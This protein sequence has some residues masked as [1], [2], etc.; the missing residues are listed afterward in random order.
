M[1]DTEQHAG[2]RPTKFTP[3]TQAT[4]VEAIRRGNSYDNAAQL[5]GVTYRTFRNWMERGEL[6][7]EEED[8]TDPFFQFFQEATRANAE[9]LDTA[10][11]GFN[12]RFGDD[13]RAPLEALA[14]RDRKNWGKQETHVL[15]DERSPQHQALPTVQIVITPAYLRQVADMLERP[16]LPEVEPEYIEV[17]ARPAYA[18]AENG[19]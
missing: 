6:A 18:A 12:A 10:V 7:T 2:G 5:A 4:I 15:R 16:A 1:N 19:D 13:Y 8:E 17:S 3:E 14:R 9:Y 11:Q